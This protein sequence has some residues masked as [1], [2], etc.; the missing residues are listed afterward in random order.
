MTI[1]ITPHNANYQYQEKREE[2]VATEVYVEN[3]PL[4]A[5]SD[6]KPLTNVSSYPSSDQSRFF[7]R[8]TELQDIINSPTPP[9]LN[10]LQIGLEN[11]KKRK[12]AKLE[13]IP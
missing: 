6:I 3:I 4:L 7:S 1:T 13:L 11:Q 5:I 12:N 10:A 8:D 9:N 2:K